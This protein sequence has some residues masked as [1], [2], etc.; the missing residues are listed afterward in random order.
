S[1]NDTMDYLRQSADAGLAVAVVSA[2]G[3]TRDAK[4]RSSYAGDALNLASFRETS[5]LEFGADDAFILA[6]ADDGETV[7][8]RH[9]KSRHGECRDLALRFTGRLQRFE[10]PAAGEPTGKLQPALASLWA[11]T[12]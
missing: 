3:R 10:A 12:R 7:T 1:V 5:E 6:A 9:L 2:V 4:G 8:L 11:R